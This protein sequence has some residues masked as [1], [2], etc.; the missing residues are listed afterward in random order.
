M[1]VAGDESACTGKVAILRAVAGSSPSG[2]SP[3]ADP[4]SIRAIVWNGRR[5][6]RGQ[7]PEG[8]P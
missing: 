2:A 7:L 6:P 3:G 5:G 1:N 8:S 4:Q